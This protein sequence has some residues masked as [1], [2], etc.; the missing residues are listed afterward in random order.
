MLLRAPAA[1]DALDRE[2]PLQQLS[3]RSQPG[4]GIVSHVH[5][6]DPAT[7]RDERLKIAQRL[8]LLQAREAVGLARHRQI[9]AALGHELHKDTVSRPPLW[10][11]PVECRSAARS[12]Q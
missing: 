6:Q 11:W 4:H 1:R 2:Y 7:M 9:W 12:R 5:A 3:E 10:Y 8:S